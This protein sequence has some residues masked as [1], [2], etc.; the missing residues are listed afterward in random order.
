MISHIAGLKIVVEKAKGRYCMLHITTLMNVSDNPHKS[1][2]T[3]HGLSFLIEYDGTRI[4]FDTGYNEDFIENAER[5]KVDLTNLNAVVLSHGHYDHTA[6]Y[7]ALMNKG[8]APEYLFVGKNFFDRKYKNYNMK[9]VNISSNLSEDALK[10][11][12]IDI[13][14]IDNGLHFEKNIYF[15]S[16]FTEA[17]PYEKIPPEYI[18][19]KDDGFVQDKFTDEVCVVLD[20]PKGLVI[21]T[22][23]SHIGLCNVLDKVYKVFN[24]PIHAVIGGFPID[25]KDDMRTK[26]TVSTLKEYNVKYL[27]YCP[28]KPM[29]TDAFKLDSINVDIV[30][31]G[32]EFF[33]MYE[34]TNN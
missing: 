4:L 5:M 16:G 19:L 26:F 2:K 33:L 14:T 18:I 15:V 7:M 23:S 28:S 11:Q 10:K 32:D 31:V 27:G 1:L 3:H 9:Y 25:T 12:N 30:A 20:T 13:R 8:L 6:G 34:S 24:K 17:N 22:G 29:A 21:V